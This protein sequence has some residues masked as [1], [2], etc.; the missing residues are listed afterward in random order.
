M[1]IAASLAKTGV[2]V[3]PV[4]VNGARLPA[5]SALPED[6][7]GLTD[8]NAV[9][10]R[11]NSWTSDVAR[12]IAALRKVG[13]L[14]TSRRR[15]ITLAVA[16]AGALAVVL[17][18]SVGIFAMRIAVPEIP[19]DMAYRHAQ[20]LIESRGLSFAGHKITSMGDHRGMMIAFD[21]RPEPGTLLFWRQTVEVDFM[22]HEFYYLVCSGGGSFD[23]DAVDG[24]YSFEKFEDKASAKMRQGSC[25]WIDRTM[26]ADEAKFIK[27]LGL[28]NDLGKQLRQAPGGL[29][30][31]CSKSQYIASASPQLVAI[32]VRNF[33]KSG[34]D[35][36]L[37]QDIT[38]GLCSDSR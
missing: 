13:A 37:V 11:S 38:D 4:L 12:L 10:I 33:L 20:Q 15:W 25:A 16:G 2:T 32:E 23:G 3:I 21:Q 31:L 5:T 30:A 36:E 27:P 24:V 26:N 29:L 17:A 7:Q 6:M 18:A 22:R 34:P 28:G 19:K 9:E 1:E 14:P 8:M 35:G